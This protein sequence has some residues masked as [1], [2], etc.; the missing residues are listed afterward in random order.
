MK[1]YLIT[2]A[3]GFI[4]FHVSKTLLEGGDA[5]TGYDNLN[6]Y[7]D[8]SLKHSRLALLKEYPSFNFVKG[9]LEDA[10]LVSETIRPD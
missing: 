8:V 9:A 10:A 2:G 3:A 5:V 4:G 7:Y 6:E 1:K